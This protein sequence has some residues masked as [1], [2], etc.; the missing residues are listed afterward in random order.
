MT[1]PHGSRD[2]AEHWAQWAAIFLPLPPILQVLDFIPVL[3]LLSVHIR[4]EN[5]NPTLHTETNSD[6]KLNFGMEDLGL[7]FHLAGSDKNS[8]GFKGF[9]IAFGMNRQNDFNNR[10][11]MEGTNNKNSLL[12]GYV[13]T[14]NNTPGGITPSMINDNYPFD[15]ALAYNTDLIY[16]PIQLIKNT[17]MMHRTED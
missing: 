5:S 13:N 7:V 1:V 2:L 12:T 3:N 14:L 15:I 17:R 11:F 6:N 9:N 4:M 10:I 16:L 8:S